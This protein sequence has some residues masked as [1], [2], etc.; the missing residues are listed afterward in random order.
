[1]AGG[2]NQVAAQL[3]QLP[4]VDGTREHTSGN[5]SVEPPAPGI[6]EKQ[7]FIQRRSSAKRPE[8]AR[9]PIASRQSS[10]GKRQRN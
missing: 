7:K 8:S 3:Q 10:G 4:E 1:M 2:V 5:G 9:E 6:S